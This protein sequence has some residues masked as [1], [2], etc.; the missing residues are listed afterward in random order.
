MT[1]EGNDDVLVEKFTSLLHHITNEHSWKGNSH[2]HQCAHE[3]H[4]DDDIRDIEW[5][6]PASHDFRLL[7]SVVQDANF[8]KDLRHTKHYCHTGSLESYHNV[9]LKYLPKKSHF[10]YDGMV[11]RGML[12][13]IDHNV[14]VGREVNRTEVRYSKPTKKFVE[15]SIRFEKDNSWRKD[16]VAKVCDIVGGRDCSI[17]DDPY[18]IEVSANI[19]SIAWPST[20]ELRERRFSRFQQY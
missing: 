14:N 15:R 6:D 19:T 16:L 20:E 18:H 1:C 11:L 13:I 7:S 12:A 4:D 2:F 3:E 17:E 9:R 8:I 5:L 10:S